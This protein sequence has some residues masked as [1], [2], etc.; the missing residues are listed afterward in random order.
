MKRTITYILG[1]ITGVILTTVIYFINLDRTFVVIES[2]YQI[3]NIGYIQKGTKLRI[4]KGFPEGFTQYSLIL[5]LSDSEKTELFESG[6]W[7]LTIPYWL[8]LANSDI[9]IEGDLFF[10]LISLGSF[11]NVPK[12][13]KDEF[14]LKIDSLKQDTS[15]SNQEKELVKMIDL[16]TKHDLIDKPYFHLKIDSTRITTVYLTQIDYNKIQQFDRQEL[17]NNEKKIQLK[18]LGEEISENIFYA[19]KI[20]EINEIDGKTYWRK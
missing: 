20:L 13:K 18:L 11:Y 7:N 5:N 12:D 1:L 6:K 9:E 3:E 14:L 8:R 2:D 19:N 15:I 17:I 16:L 10:K 4:E